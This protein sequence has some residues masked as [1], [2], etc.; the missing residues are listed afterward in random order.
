MAG[1]YT[2]TAT[3]SASSLPLLYSHICLIPQFALINVAVELK[4]KKLIWSRLISQLK[5]AAAFSQLPL[6]LPPL[7]LP[8]PTRFVVA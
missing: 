3:P 4:K 6:P 1:S 7:S 5:S 8:T 2:S